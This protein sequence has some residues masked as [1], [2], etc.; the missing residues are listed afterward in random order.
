MYRAWLLW[1]D[2]QTLKAAQ[3]DVT[4][5]T[6]QQIDLGV[7]MPVKGLKQLTSLKVAW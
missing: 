1:A 3:T 6:K 4:H 2:K 5:E 7:R